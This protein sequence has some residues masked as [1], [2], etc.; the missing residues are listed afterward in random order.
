MEP[1][2][3]HMQ[4]SPVLR[5]AVVLR[6]DI[7]ELYFNLNLAYHGKHILSQSKPLCEKLTPNFT[8]C[9]RKKGEYILYEGSIHDRLPFIPKGEY[10]VTLELFNEDNYRIACG[11]VTILSL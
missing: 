1:C 7:N 2:T 3:K 8:F 6:R 10:A 5:I 4:K 11:N 9:G